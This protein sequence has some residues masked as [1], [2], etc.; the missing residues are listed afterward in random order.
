MNISQK[1][2]D[3]IKGFEGCYLTGYKDI[4][5]VP[6]VGYGTTGPDIVVG[7]KITQEQAE[8]ML[9]DDLRGFEQAVTNL[10]KV[11]LNQNEF[12]ALVSFTYNVGANALRNSTLLKLLNDGADRSTVANEFLRWNKV[13]G[14]SIEGLTRR[15]KA[16][17]ELFLSKPKHELLS[18]SIV[19][20]EDTWLKRKPVQSSELKAEE[21][22]FVPKGSAHEWTSITE[23]PGEVHKK[24]CL[25]AGPN[26]EWWMFPAHWKTINDVTEEQPAR[27]VLD[28]PY[29]SQ[30]DNAADPSRTCFSSSCAMMLKYLM[31]NSIS[32]D[33]E[34]IREVYK[35][36]D[37]TDSAAQ[38]KTLGAFGL[39]ASFSQTGSWSDLDELLADGIPVP[40]G[41]LHKGPV[42]A[43]TGG[44]HWICVIGRTADRTAYIVNDPWGEMDL[45]GGTYISTNGAG[46]KYSKKNL[47]KRWLIENS[48]SGWFIRAEP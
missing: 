20:K 47:G 48:Y 38:L 3:L 39:R 21:K 30:R 6:T 46:L 35:H 29:Y 32:G 14:N 9:R 42:T 37:T 8:Q 17:R 18:T 10:V 2:V 24:V 12:D 25:A 36:G 44:G 23:Y 15:R 40:I 41:I 19:A 27:L 16:E 22:L 33:D 28:V 43:P 7:M 34:Y 11:G 31:P 5:G 13:N 45:I 1:G 26:P 4:A